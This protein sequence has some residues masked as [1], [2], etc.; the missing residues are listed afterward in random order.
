MESHNLNLEWLKGIRVVL[1]GHYVPAPLSA[2]LLGRMG[3]EVIKVEQDNGDY[4]RAMPSPS[5]PSGQVVSPMFRMLNGGFKSLALQ[6]KTPQGAALLRELLAKSDVVID[7]G[8]V[9]V[10]EQALGVPLEQISRQL[11]Y[12]PITAYG[13]IGPMATLA[14]HD[15]NILAM[16][17]NLSYTQTT[18]AGAPTVFSAPV[19]DMFAGQM[20]AI[21]V[22]AALMGRDRSMDGPRR[23]DPSMLH[24]GFFLNFLELASRNAPG[25]TQAQP[26]KAWMNGGRP[27]YRPYR[28]RDGKWVYFGLLESWSLKRFL[29]GIG[30]ASLLAYL[31]EPE[32]LASH[33]ETLFSQRD[34]A[35]W[36]SIGAEFDACITAVNDL[37]SAIAAPQVR[38]LGLMQEVDDPD[39]GTISLPT[40]PMGFGKESRQP[41][42]P[43]SAPRLGQHSM[44]IL[45]EIL[46]LDRQTIDHLVTEK[47][48]RLAE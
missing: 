4:L 38:A 19:A 43:L 11:I 1:I 23:I 40:F 45:T 13:Q 48:V 24:A 35:E 10:L 33:F 28:T 32:K 46:G 25:Y 3:A 39:L 41:S 29:H 37:E 12:A 42:L 34:Q 30:Q 20:A 27:D 9:G 21:G 17:G 47:I 16:A 44:E 36:V 2:M 8:R 15:N 14:G 6:W 5:P 26:G 22:L 18:S 31:E 7:G